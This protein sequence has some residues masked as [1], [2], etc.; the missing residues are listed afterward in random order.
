VRRAC[1]RLVNRGQAERPPIDRMLEGG[2]HAAGVHARTMSDRHG[3]LRT[4]MSRNP[5][6]VTIRRALT[7]ADREARAAV[8]GSPELS[9]LAASVA[10]ILARS[11]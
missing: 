4:F 5:S 1:A 10:G 7:D 6:G 2:L 9:A 8:E 3:N 11:R